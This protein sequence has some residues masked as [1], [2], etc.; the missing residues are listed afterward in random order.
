MSQRVMAIVESLEANGLLGEAAFRFGA[1]DRVLLVSGGPLSHLARWSLIAAPATKRVVVRQPARSEIPAAEPHHPLE[2]DVRLVDD[3]PLLRADVEEWK[4]GSWY[5]S[6]TLR[7]GGLG[8]LFNKLG[9]ITAQDPFERTH[10]VQLPHRP[11]WSGALAYDLVQWTQ[12][13]RLQHPPEEGAIL[14]V[15]WCVENGVVVDHASGV[16]AVFG[17]DGAWCDAASNLELQENTSVHVPT[18]TPHREAVTH[19]DETHAD[20]VEAVREGIVDGQVYQVNIG[21]H[22]Q[23]EIDHPYAV[24]QRLMRDNPAPFSAYV[25]AQDLGLA[26]ASSSPESLLVVR[27]GTLQTSPIKGTC[28]QGSTREEA[29]KFREAMISDQKERAEHRMLVDLM[30]NDLTQV[31]EPGSINVERFDV[32]SYANVQHLVSHITA[33]LKPTLGGAEALDAVFPGGSITGCP[34]TVVCAVIDELEQWPRSFWTGSIG[35]IDVHGGQSAWNILIRTL[36]AHRVGG[37]W[38]ATVGAGGGITIAS[39][40]K[41]EVEEAA[42]KGAALRI[43][44]GWMRREHTALPSGTLGIHPLQ[45]PGQAAGGV[46]CGRILELEQQGDEAPT[47]GVLFVDNLDSF[48]LNIADAVAQTGRDV[49]VVKGRAPQNERWLD[50]V[51]LHDLL[52]RLEPSHL[53]LGPGPG[54]PD[55]AVLTMAL[56]HHALAGQLP[57]PVLG[58]CLGH[59]ALAL[60]DGRQVNPSPFG[61][62]HGVPVDIEHDGTGVFPAQPG[63]LKL[64]RYNSLVAVENGEHTLLVNATES[65]SGLIMGLRHPT[66]PV[67]GVQFHPE[68]IGSRDGQQL[69]HQFLSSQAD[70]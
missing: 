69:I 16:T 5:H 4:H 68:S 59:Q 9:G 31:A 36:E 66:L 27:D 56:A 48:S 67:H 23:G 35:Y 43:A 11:F 3:H 20:N 21:K 54:R 19:T 42:W 7:A 37:R 2:G 57:M 64:T 49:V 25:H 60:A 44:A 51:A 39:E 17:S 30:R 24:F 65:T 15:L 47:G 1:P 46:S 53:I 52:D 62:V 8:D 38:Q 10:G 70:G 34:R 32:E 41:K 6:V 14:A 26:L 33:A 45:P 22:W 28:P 29:S 40:A 13:L 18:P 55:D 61:P 58:V 12:P 50:P 63:S